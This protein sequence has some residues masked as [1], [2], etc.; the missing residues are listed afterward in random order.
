MFR[1]CDEFGV[2]VE[3]RCWSRMSRCR[4]GEDDMGVGCIELDG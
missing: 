1:S 2:V 3:L 4:A